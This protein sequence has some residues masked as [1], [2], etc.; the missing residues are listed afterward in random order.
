MKGGEMGDRVHVKKQVVVFWVQT[1]AKS[2]KGDVGS[3][4]DSVINESW[5]GGLSCDGCYELKDENVMVRWKGKD[6][7]S[8]PQKIV[9]YPIR[10]K[11]G[12]GS[13]IKRGC[14]ELG[15]KSVKGNV[16]N[17]MINDGRLTE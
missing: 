8:S 17:H 12:G 15:E 13:Q 10:N 11:K 14:V 2:Q 1:L 3:K 5:G 4:K 7:C 6:K 9:V 16:V